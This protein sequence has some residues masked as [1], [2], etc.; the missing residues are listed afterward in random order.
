MVSLTERFLFL[1]H[2]PFIDF[3]SQKNSKERVYFILP[4]PRSIMLFFPDLLF[5]LFLSCIIIIVH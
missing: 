4:A 3:T 2:Q 1:Q 5:H